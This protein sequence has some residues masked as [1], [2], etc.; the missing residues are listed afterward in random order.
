M[1]DL[2]PDRQSKIAFLEDWLNSLTD[3]AR[4]TTV[5]NQHRLESDL[6]MDEYSKL[7]IRRFAEYNDNGASIELLTQDRRLLPLAKSG[8]LAQ[9]PMNY[10][11]ATLDDAEWKKFLKAFEAA[12]EANHQE[13]LKTQKLLTPDVNISYLARTASHVF[14]YKPSSAKATLTTA[15]VRLMQ[16]RRMDLFELVMRSPYLTQDQ[17]NQAADDLAEI[18]RKANEGFRGYKS[19]RDKQY[20]FKPMMARL[21]ALGATLTD[22]PQRGYDYPAEFEKALGT[23]PIKTCRGLFSGL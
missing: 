2:L 17:K 5:L 7:G 23:G 15:E 3:V 22:D 1:D 20:A 21:R 16:L 18:F 6:T 11:I 9:G 19:L 14:G 8:F 10:A 13:M 12:L 4:E